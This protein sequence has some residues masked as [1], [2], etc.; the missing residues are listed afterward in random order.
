MSFTLNNSIEKL[1]FLSFQIW[2]DD[3][4]LTKKFRLSLVYYLF[5][6]RESVN[7]AKVSQRQTNISVFILGSTATF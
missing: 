3:R 6:F 4:S 1:H 2:W 7:G 5:R